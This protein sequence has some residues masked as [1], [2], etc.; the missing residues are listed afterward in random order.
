MTRIQSTPAAPYSRI[1]ITTSTRCQEC[2]AEF[3][4]REPSTSGVR[5]LTDFSLSA[6]TRNSICRARRSCMRHRLPLGCAPVEVRPFPDDRAVFRRVDH[7]T[8][9]HASVLEHEVQG[10]AVLRAGKMIELEHVYLPTRAD[11]DSILNPTQIAGT[12]FDGSYSV[13]SVHIL[14]SCNAYANAR[15]AG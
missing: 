1:T 5:R 15:S 7:L 12:T 10:I 6:S 3:S 9:D 4:R 14:K 11:L 2:S 13:V 8:I